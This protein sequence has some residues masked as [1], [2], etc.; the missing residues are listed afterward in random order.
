MNAN[1]YNSLPVITGE[2]DLPETAAYYSWEGFHTRSVHQ[3]WI[4]IYDAEFNTLTTARLQYTNALSGLQRI[5]R[6]DD[7]DPVLFA[8]VRTA[9]NDDYDLVEADADTLILLE[10]AARNATIKVE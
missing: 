5:A 2:S 7:T 4:I 10:T 9:L 6:H 8:Y 3:D 1:V